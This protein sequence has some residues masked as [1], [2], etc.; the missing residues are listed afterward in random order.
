MPIFIFPC[1]NA[2]DAEEIVNELRSRPDPVQQLGISIEQ[3]ASGQP[4]V[5]VRAESGPLRATAATA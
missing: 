5:V 3:D 4:Q 2:P 1:E